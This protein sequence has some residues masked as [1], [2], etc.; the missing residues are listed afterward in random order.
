MQ[1]LK[2]SHYHSVVYGVW[3]MS[4]IIHSK[5]ICKNITDCQSQNMKNGENLARIPP[6]WSFVPLFISNPSHRL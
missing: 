4:N 5:C 3:D 6:A 1:P 2:L